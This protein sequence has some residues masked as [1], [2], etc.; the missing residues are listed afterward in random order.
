MPPPDLTPLAR[1]PGGTPP[2]TNAKLC[3]FNSERPCDL[4]C[5]AAFEVDDPVDNVDC[6]FVWL[7][8]HF[9]EGMFEFKN[10]LQNWGQSSPPGPMSG[11]QSGP[12]GHSGPG[13]AP[14]GF[15]PGGFDS[16]N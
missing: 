6:H 11:P 15:P 2:V 10:M 5:K 1:S 9:G 13:K 8:Y 7:A 4:T 14:P 16:N 12:T 3:F